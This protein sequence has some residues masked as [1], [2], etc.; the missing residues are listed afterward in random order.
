MNL[1]ETAALLFALEYHDEHDT[2]KDAVERFYRIIESLNEPQWADGAHCGD[3]TK[4]PIL[5]HQCFVEE[6]RLR[7]HN[8]ILDWKHEEFKILG[9]MLDAL[10]TH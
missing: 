9:A 7:A 5:C 6:L 10:V 3:C 1:D 4:Q 2:V 8:L